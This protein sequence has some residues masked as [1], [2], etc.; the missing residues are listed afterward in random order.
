MKRRVAVMMIVAAALAAGS[1]TLGGAQPVRASFGYQSLNTIQKRLV[2]SALIAV[3]GP[4][5]SGG[6]G[7]AAVNGDSSGDGAD[8]APNGAPAGFNPSSA[9]GG[10]PANYFP[11]GSGQCSANHGSNNVKVNTNCLNISDADLQGRGQ[12]NNETSI[13]QDPFQPS[14]IVA[15]N[16][17]YV[18][19]DGTC[20]AS[21]SLDGG[22]TWN[23]STVPNSFTRGTSFG[24][25]ARQYWQ[26]GGDTSVAWDTRGNAYLSC[27]LFNRGTVASNNPDQSS[28][29]VVFRS[30]ANGGA[31]WNFPGRE[32]EAFAQ[33]KGGPVLED[34]QLM[35]VD[36]HVSSPFRDRVYVTYTEF[37]ANGTAYIYERYSQDYGQTFSPRTLVSANS[38]LCPT[39][40][41]L[42]TPNGNCNQN[43]FSQ[44]FV[45]KDGAL[46]VGYNNFNNALNGPKDNRNQILL[47]KSTDGGSTFSA[48]VKVSDYYD[49]PDCDTYQGPRSDPG[50]ACVPEK[51]GTSNSVFRAINYSSG[52]AN[53]TNAAQVVVTVGSYINKDSRESNGCSP[54]GFAANGDN[55]YSGVKTQGA[56]NNK[57]LVSVSNDGGR[58]FSGAT[59]DPRHQAMVT[60]G[61]DQR[62]TDQF[63]QWTAFTSKG[64]F[65]S[66]YYDRQYGNDETTG[67]SDITLTTA[68]EL[69]DSKGLDDA[70]QQRVTSSSMPPPTQFPNRKGAGVFYG[71]YSGLTAVDDIHPLW[72]DTR[73]LDLFICP[74][75]ATGPGNPPKICK[76]IEPNGLT[77]N[78][79]DI[80]TSALGP[81][82][83]NIRTTK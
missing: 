82:T 49:L 2:S 78:D 11:S 24:S 18:R 63:W 65:A 69:D 56:C 45:G 29:F 41:G 51:A 53:P 25:A 64:A 62:G 38:S 74:T 71:D 30:T 10:S 20:G 76:G 81:A 73:S 77:A 54:A 57:I 67:A 55:L 70:G 48:P 44:P 59:V 46:Y 75:T 37:A 28:T 32:V 8:G 16:N 1:L 15:S 80:Y 27:Q 12:A 5:S 13:A 36:N 58:T 31:S 79:Q 68:S 39:T 34:K 23:N 9:A 3:L 22:R 60:N 40:F 83:D 21:Y 72:S 19:G 66:S 42:P 50:R 4:S 17:D 14:H 33:P 43:Q 7:Q 6:Q 35:A 26:G 47:A 61:E 52:Q